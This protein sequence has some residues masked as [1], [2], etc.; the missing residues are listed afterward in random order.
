MDDEH[1]ALDVI[2]RV[3]IG[4][5]FLGQRHTMDHLRQEHFLPKLVD[6]RSYDLWVADGRRTIEE[7]A[8]AKV[9]NA[10]AHPPPHPLTPDV[11]RELDNLIDDAPRGAA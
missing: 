10:L 8:R 11:V 9:V 6:R 1:L 4:G 2:E 7:R 3:G 5:T